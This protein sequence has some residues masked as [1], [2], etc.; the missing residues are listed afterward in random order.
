ML[1]TLQKKGHQGLM[2]ALKL[3]AKL[4]PMTKP[5]LFT[6]EGSSAQ[7]CEAIAQMGTGKILIV[8]DAMLV[9]LGVVKPI[10]DALSQYN[11]DY[12]IY[13]GVLPDPTYDQ[14]E[15]GLE[16]YEANGCE[17]ILAIGGGSSIDCAKVIAARVTNKRPIPKLSG[18]FR[19]WNAPA[20]LF[21]IPTTAGT[22]SEVTIAAVVSDPESHKKTLI[23]DLKLV[24]MMAALDASLMLG[25]PASVTAATGMDALTHA[26]EAFI[27]KN[28]TPDTDGYAMAATRLIMENLPVAV[29]DG[30]NVKARHNM[31]LAS[32]YAGLAF[33]K[34][35]LG[36][37]HAISHNFG[38]LYKTPHGLGNA[39]VLPYVLDY[40]KEDI[41]ERLATL[42]EV[43]G[44]K[45]GNES[46]E[47]L[48]DQFI[49]RIREMLTEFDIPQKLQALKAE[50]VP[51]IAKS[52]LREAHTNYPV[53]KYLDQERCEALIRQMIA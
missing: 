24:P 11:V 28:A 34:A 32:Y 43:S 30:S 22:G 7:L 2:G 41:V 5:T 27:S 47:A 40:S 50:D 20:P 42:A 35:S 46:Q 16:M 53:P 38:A 23:M 1:F 6:G 9:K 14:V 51:A 45:S 49:A 44:L 26:V 31:A 12:L 8:T 15:T 4:V 21:A 29:K 13:D 52:A 10:L 3:A 37:V 33:T 48:A 36:Y 19:V 18:Y 25:L 39:I 17:A